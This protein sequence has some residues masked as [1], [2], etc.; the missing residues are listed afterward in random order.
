MYDMYD[1]TPN[2]QQFKFSGSVVSNLQ[3]CHNFLRFTPSQNSSIEHHLGFPEKRPATLQLM[4]KGYSYTNIQYYQN[5][6]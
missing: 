3:D 5:S 4:R 1:H 6:L 2:L